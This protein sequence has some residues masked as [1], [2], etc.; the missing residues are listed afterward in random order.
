[1][2]Q[3]NIQR[4]GLWSLLRRLL[5]TMFGPIEGSKYRWRKK[6][7]TTQCGAPALRAVLCILRP[8]AG[9]VFASRDV[10]E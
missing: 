3:N 9:D 10:I 6:Q 1:M 2:E 4:G 7:A 5:E 8:K